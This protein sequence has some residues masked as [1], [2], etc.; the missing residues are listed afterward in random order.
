MLMLCGLAAGLV[1]A[2]STSPASFCGHAGWR[3]DWG[4]EI[5]GP[6]VDT[7]KWNVEDG[8]DIG[9]CRTAYC[10]PDNVH[11]RNGSLVL[12]SDRRVLRGRNFTTGAVTTKHKMAWAPRNGSFRVCVSAKLPGAPGKGAGLWPAHWLMPL[13]SACDPDLGEMDTMEMVDADGIV[14]ATYHW[15][16]TFPRQPCAYPKGHEKVTKAHTLPAGWHERYHEF[17]VER[18][19]DHIAFAVDGAVVLSRSGT[20][21]RFNGT[22]SSSAVAQKERA[23]AA[24]GDEPMLWDV[25]WYLIL[26]TAIGGSWP[27]APDAN[28]A[29]PAE[30]SIDYVR[31]DVSA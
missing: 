9:A 22:R 31:V 25:P 14:H 5:D 3:R 8:T 15:E 12:T 13:P 1:T 28:T 24:A 30:H 18:G 11:V 4:D 20:Q 7:G 6:S 17:A 27:G 21:H 23:D 19:V 2:A 16:T 10:T 26:N 29:F